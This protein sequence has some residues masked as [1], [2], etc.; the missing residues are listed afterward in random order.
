MRGGPQTVSRA[1]VAQAGDLDEFIGYLTKIA[2]AVDQAVEPSSHL[3]DDLAFEAIAF[4]R[5]GEWAQHRFGVG[6]I[7]TVSLRSDCLTVESFFRNCILGP[8]GAGAVL[9]SASPCETGE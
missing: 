2:P 5:L 6:G 3:F 1:L 9:V 8:L 4:S 7:S